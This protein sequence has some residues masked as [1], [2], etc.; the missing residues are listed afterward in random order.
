MGYE[1][2]I[3]LFIFRIYMDFKIKS[4]GDI[5]LNISISLWLEKKLILKDFMF[6]ICS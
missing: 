4:T 6:I 1:A 3:Y 2:C 5:L